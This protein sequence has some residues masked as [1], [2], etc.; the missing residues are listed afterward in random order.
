MFSV[1][2]Y[3]LHYLLNNDGGTWCL[4]CTCHIGCG[5]VH[6]IWCYIDSSRIARTCDTNI[7]VAHAGRYHIRWRCIHLLHR[8]FNIGMPFLQIVHR[9]REKIYTQIGHRWCGWWLMSFIIQRDTNR[10][11]KRKKESV[12][13]LQQFLTFQNVM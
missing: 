5:F 13:I 6:W 10:K 12:R 11:K 3:T 4:C 7:C 8:N 2:V 9:F 1:S